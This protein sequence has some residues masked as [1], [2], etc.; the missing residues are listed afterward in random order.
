[1]SDKDLELETNPDAIRERDNDADLHCDGKDGYS[2]SARSETVFPDVRLRS[3]AN[4]PTY[5]IPP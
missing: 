4:P 1:M 5:G 3:H 2:R